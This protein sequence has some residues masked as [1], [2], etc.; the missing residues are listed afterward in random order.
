VFGLGGGEGRGRPEEA[1]EYG[2]GE[3]GVREEGVLGRTMHSVRDAIGGVAGGIAGIAKG[4][5]INVE[6]RTTY[7]ICLR[8]LVKPRQ[9]LRDSELEGGQATAR[10]E[11][12]G[13]AS[14]ERIP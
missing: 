5:T 11:Q 1:R 10:G 3:R 8:A 4:R 12:Q 9:D 2:R 7:P 14:P 13:E 6:S